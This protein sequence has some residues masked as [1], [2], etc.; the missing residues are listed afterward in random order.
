MSSHVIFSRAGLLQYASTSNLRAGLEAVAAKTEA[1]IGVTAGWDGFEWLDKNGNL[2]S[3]AALEL[4]MVDKL[5]ARDV[6]LGAFTLAIGEEKDMALAARFANA[7]ACL[8]SSKPGGRGAIP[9]RTEI[10]E[11]LETP[12][13]D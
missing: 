12:D 9:C 4:P 1:R 13:V 3:V 2:Q 5:G 11:Q 8:K 6:F 7:A 10:W